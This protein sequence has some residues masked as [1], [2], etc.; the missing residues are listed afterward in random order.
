MSEFEVDNKPDLNKGTD[1]HDAKEVAETTTTLKHELD[2][3]EDLNKKDNT[4]TN[5][6]PPH[7]REIEDDYAS[8]K[9]V[10][11]VDD[12]VSNAYSE[13]NTKAYNRFWPDFLKDADELE[14]APFNKDSELPFELE[15][16]F[17]LLKGNLNLEFEKTKMQILT[18]TETRFTRSI[19]NILAKNEVY[20]RLRFAYES[21][22]NTE[23]DI[24]PETLYS[25]QKE[26][27]RRVEDYAKAKEEYLAAVSE[28]Y[29]R[30]H[31]NELTDDLD[32]NRQAIINDVTKAVEAKVAE[33]RLALEIAISPEIAKSTI[34]LKHKMLARFD[35]LEVQ[36]DS[37]TAKA[38]EDF[39]RKVRREMRRARNQD[40]QI[41]VSDLDTT[42]KDLREFAEEPIAEINSTV[43]TPYTNNNPETE[44]QVE[45]KLPKDP[46]L[47]AVLK[48]PGIP[49]HRETSPTPEVESTV[50]TKETSQ[51]AETPTEVET[52]DTSFDPF[53]TVQ[54]PLTNMF[55]SQAPVEKTSQPEVST[56]TPSVETD[57]FDFGTSASEMNTD[58]F[59]IDTPAPEPVATTKEDPAV[60]VDPFDFGN[61]TTNTDTEDPFDPFAINPNEDPTPEITDPF[62]FDTLGDDTPTK[63][64]DAD[65][66]LSETGLGSNDT[67]T[68]EK[69]DA[70]KLDDAFSV[71]NM[72]ADL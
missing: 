66:T 11:V 9:V 6:L 10:K 33:T 61:T 60:D 21:S 43:E 57:P 26:N 39:K 40:V 46:E 65:S 62:N 53:G 24:S 56:E 23:S 28:Q 51:P 14:P 29:D 44:A 8:P 12:M 63:S 35:E 54:E 45:T 34:P 52:P 20:Q 4:E 47:D 22:M 27:H 25:Y 69:S 1:Q 15:Q 41:H 55:D 68:E 38:I 2:G 18:Q 72:F 36:N 48:G 37:S 67:Q 50:E 31:L 58:P 49:I 64:F 30:D 7:L 42:S 32:M 17:D 5:P 19:G 16:H 59:A 13:L 70:E 3:F 71:D